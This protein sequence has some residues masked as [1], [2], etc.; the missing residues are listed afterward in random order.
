M[1]GTRWMKR[2]ILL[3]TVVGTAVL[4]ATG[5][6]LAT[7]PRGTLDA[8]TITTPGAPYDLNGSTVLSPGYPK[9]QQFT[10]KH[11]GIIN[12]VQFQL[13]KYNTP[14]DPV[15]V[16]LAETDDSGLPTTNILSETSV[17]ASAVPAGTSAESPLVTANFSSPPTVEKDKKYALVWSTA[18]STT[19]YQFPLKDG[20]PDPDGSR[21]Y[22]LSSSSDWQRDDSSAD[23]VYAIYVDTGDT[24][25]PVIS[26]I[27]TSALI[28]TANSSDG[29]TVTFPTITASDTVDGTLE[30]NCASASGLKSGDTFPIG[31]TAVN[32]SVTD[33]NGNTATRTFDVTVD[34]PPQA[35]DV[36]D[37]STR[38]DVAKDVTLSATDGDND[39]L[40]Y[41]VTALPANGKLYKG[42]GTG[43]AD[44]ITSTSLPF[45]LPTNG[46]KV[47]YM[48]N[49]NFNGSDSFKF[50]ANDGTT[51]S[52]EAT[53]SITVDAVNDAP[54]FSLPAS[55]N[56]TVKQGAGAQTVSSF[57][58][59][60]SAGPDNESTQ[61]V[62]FNVTNDNSALFSGQP[63]ISSDGTLTYT[64]DAGKSGTA[65]VSVQA[66]DDGGTTNGGQDTSA[67]KTFTI[68][69]NVNDTVA[70]TVSSVTPTLSTKVPRNAPITA[71]FS[72]EMKTDT[73]K[74][75][76]FKLQKA[77]VSKGKTT[78]QDVPGVSVASQS[79]TG[80][81]NTPVTK[82]TLT[83]P[84]GVLA[85]NTTYKVTITNGAQDLAGN[86]LTPEKVWSFKTAR[87]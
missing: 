51:D 78:Y 71:T 29:A 33:A 30:V 16:Q 74:T 1:A 23:H 13:W 53:V 31:T 19:Q 8:N 17:E 9:A 28:V 80:P 60:I 56:Q 49:P 82:A 36:N 25:P 69:V 43:A 5:M 20:N 59:A 32:C 40:S 12:R 7:V 87:K 77:V 4:L 63:A 84:N 58:T 24:T 37:V 26:G 76:T 79:I 11:S 50:L 34:Q 55:P 62:G 38:E 73:L 3:L 14:V 70:P 57:A 64:P 6:A 85:A 86:A 39:P 66:Y 61:T 81:N 67:A 54:S 2:M 35:S 44:E 52:N 41:K 15:K 68:T 22:T 21:E 48:P 83:P 75:T 10:A 18:T 47:T 42:S 27:P 46:N 72:E 65:T 45:T